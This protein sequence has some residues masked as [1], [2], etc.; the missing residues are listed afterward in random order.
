MIMA[1]GYSGWATG[2]L[3]EEIASNGWLSCDGCPDILFDTSVDRKYEKALAK[4][5]IDISLL[6]SEAGH[7]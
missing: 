7:A 2:Q 6:S 4:L 5:G 1:L 3:E